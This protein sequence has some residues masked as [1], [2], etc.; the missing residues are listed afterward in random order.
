MITTDTLPDELAQ[1]FT[2]RKMWGLQS[3]LAEGEWSFLQDA[4]QNVGT[5]NGVA[6]EVSVCTAKQAGYIT[7]KAT[8]TPRQQGAT[9][10]AQWGRAFDIKPKVV[11]LTWWN[12]WAA[13]RQ[14]DDASGNPQFVDEYDSGKPLRW[15]AFSQSTV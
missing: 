7:D 13:Q 2:L 3:A 15:N 6:E 5:T 9:F 10:Q 11:M 1:S 8:A 12:E 14:V 4:P